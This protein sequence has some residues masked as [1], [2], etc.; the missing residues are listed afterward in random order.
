M[1]HA[2]ES[3]TSFV[4]PQE[5]RR[6][7]HFC[8]MMTRD[9]EAAEDLAQEKLLEAW[10]HLEGLRDPEKRSQWLTGIARNVCRR[11]RRQSSHDLAHHVPLEASLEQDGVI[12]EEAFADSFD[13][14]VELERK[15]LVVL[16]DRAM[17]ALPP[18]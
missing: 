1:T 15:E 17:S 13:I 6:L 10:R 4:S 16:L 14:E 9:S 18:G 12:P 7:V 3:T 2:I 5:C 11:W 8:A